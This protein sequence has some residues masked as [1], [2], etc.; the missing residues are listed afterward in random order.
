MTARPVRLRRP[1]RS[2]GER[3][4]RRRACPDQLGRR[5]RSRWTG[6]AAS[7]PPAVRE[8]SGASVRSGQMFWP[9]G[10]TAPVEHQPNFCVRTMSRWVI[11]FPSIRTAVRGPRTGARGRRR[12]MPELERVRYISRS[13]FLTAHQN[14]ALRLLARPSPAL[15][16]AP[17]TAAALRRPLRLRDRPA[18]ARPA[19]RGRRPARH[20]RG[21]P[22]Q[23]APQGPQP[24][25]PT[26][27]RT[28]I[29]PALVVGA[30]PV[31]LAVRRAAGR[32]SLM[33]YPDQGRGRRGWAQGRAP[34]AV[35]DPVGAPVPKGP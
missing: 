26:C 7:Q 28:D 21:H 6:R 13:T 25:R 30:G 34:A 8:G 23:P 10:R 11:P 9:A 33:P 5:R 1:D 3:P 31:Q 4:G 19:A 29:T 24:R 2:P 12:S 18:P 16:T 22:H 17:R 35:Q 27:A 20:H 32:P 14:Q 15:L